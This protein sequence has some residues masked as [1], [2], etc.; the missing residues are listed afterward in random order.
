M[1]KGIFPFSIL[2]LLH[3]SLIQISQRKKE[4]RKILLSFIFQNRFH[5]WKTFLFLERSFYFHSSADVLATHRPP[6]ADSARAQD[7]TNYVFCRWSL[8][9]AFFCL[10]HKHTLDCCTANYIFPPEVQFEIKSTYRQC[11]DFT[12]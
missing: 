3:P 4:E 12:V 6:D 5:S 8:S 11:C 7:W 9:F 2:L 10:L 1:K